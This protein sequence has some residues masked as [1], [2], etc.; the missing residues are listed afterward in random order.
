M[1][2][3]VPMDFQTQ[4]RVRDP[5]FQDIQ[6]AIDVDNMKEETSREAE[7]LGGFFNGVKG[8]KK[9]LRSADKKI[10]LVMIGYW[11]IPKRLMEF[12]AE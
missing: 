1:S 3:G 7:K 9:Y 5:V 10:S 6:T 12:P 11:L 8:R 4:R 2:S